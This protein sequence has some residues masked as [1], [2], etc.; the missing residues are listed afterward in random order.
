MGKRDDDIPRG[1]SQRDVPGGQVE[2]QMCQRWLF[3]SGC[4]KVRYTTV[5][6]PTEDVPISRPKCS[7]GTQWSVIPKPSITA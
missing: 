1:K 7:S 2:S 6:C 4:P 5:N 3:Q